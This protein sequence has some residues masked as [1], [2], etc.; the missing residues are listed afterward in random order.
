MRLLVADDDVTVR[1]ELAELL[2]EEGH[3]VD[4]ATDG[5]DAMRKLEAGF[6]DAALLDLKMPRATGLEVLRRV[7]VARPDT[8]VIMITGQGTI[9]A[10]VEAMKLGATDFVEKP[11][12]IEAIQRT[13]RGL[14][15]ERQAR[16]MLSRSASTNDALRSLVEDAV[17][18]KA[19]LAV[20]GASGPHLAGAARTLRIAED[21]RPPDVFSPA[22][23]Y[24]INVA[25]EDH[26]ARTEQAVVYMADLGL[27]ERTHGRSDLKAWIRQLS[28]RCEGRS[29]T[30]ILVSRDPTL[31]MEIEAEAGEPWIDAGLQ[32]MLESLANPIR[33][34]I[35][36]Y[37]HAA[38]PVAY[39]AILKRNF[40]DSSS[41]L[42]FHLQKLQAD[43]LL[44]KQKD[45]SYGLTEEGRH[46]W[47]VVRALSE[48]RRRPSLLFVPQ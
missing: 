38:G 32:G 17:R 8:A 21:P 39:S 5:L 36:S 45:G 9:D 4:T 6:F 48:E 19:L 12:E 44:T 43:A 40:V 27:I 33:R 3:E 20:L 2:R 29:G 25:I 23:L 7:R 37:V 31:A 42:S 41:K 30:L 24:Q 14:S 10:A 13:L 35:V 1:S 34:A 16:K 11:F 26:L 47:R 28:S 22:Q 46:A 18:R 15:E